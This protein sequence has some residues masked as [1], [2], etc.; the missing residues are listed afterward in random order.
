VTSA[1]PARRA[2]TQ[3]NQ[4]TC[5]YSSRIRSSGRYCTPVTVLLTPR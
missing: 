2:M 4:P 1:M 5:A 3:D